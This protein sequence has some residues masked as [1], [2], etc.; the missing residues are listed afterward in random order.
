MGKD[1]SMY[2]LTKNHK[3]VDKLGNRVHEEIRL[4]EEGPPR[5]EMMGFKLVS[6]ILVQSVMIDDTSK[7]LYKRNDEETEFFYLRSKVPEYMVTE[8]KIL[9][10][11]TRVPISEGQNMMMLD[12]HGLDWEMLLTT[13]EVK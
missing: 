6:S 11:Y 8:S 2:L 4:D 1:G 5:V 7:V 3:G 13:N 10:V 12:K 9:Y